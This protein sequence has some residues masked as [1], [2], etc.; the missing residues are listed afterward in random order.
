[1]NT[2]LQIYNK[3]NID[4][5]TFTSWINCLSP[6]LSILWPPV[7]LT[8][9][10]SLFIET[11]PA[12]IRL[13]LSVCLSSVVWISSMESYSSSF[14]GLF[15]AIVTSFCLFVVH[16]CLFLHH[17]CYRRC[18]HLLSP[19]PDVAELSVQWRLQLFQ[20]LLNC[21]YRFRFLHCQQP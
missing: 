7:L 2:I 1:M 14:N 18:C 20:I 15:F 13:S 17:V 8:E 6:L 5:I 16:I 12:S 9:A 4:K 10:I 19:V 21:H 11:S 3:L